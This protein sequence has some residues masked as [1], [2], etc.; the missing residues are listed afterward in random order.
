MS[1]ARFI[2]SLTGHAPTVPAAIRATCID[3]GISISDLMAPAKR[4]ARISRARFTAYARLYAIT[5]SVNEVARIMGK[6]HTTV[7]HGIRRYKEQ[8]Q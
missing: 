6:N 7:I 5:D 3:H 8:A 4:D 2:A 1:R